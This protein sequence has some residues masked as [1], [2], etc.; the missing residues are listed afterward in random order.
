[1]HSSYFP[2]DQPDYDHRLDKTINQPKQVTEKNENM[3]EEFELHEI[4]LRLVGPIR[5]IGKTESDEERF[6]NL[7][8]LCEITKELLGLIEDVGIDF[9]HR[10]E[11]SVKHA[12]DYAIAFMNKIRNT[13]EVQ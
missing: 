9:S 2:Y 8:R 1:M 10:H 5:P 11:H 7:Q 13:H 6:K 12:S 4:V 3:K